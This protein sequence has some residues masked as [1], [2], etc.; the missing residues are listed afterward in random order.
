MVI[1]CD[2]LVHF[3]LKTLNFRIGSCFNKLFNKQTLIKKENKLNFFHKLKL[4]Y[5]KSKST[6]E[7]VK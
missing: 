1:F 7:E 5:H 3:N 6:F 2:L 4:A